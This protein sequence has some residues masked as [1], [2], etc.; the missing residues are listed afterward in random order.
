MPSALP[1]TSD[2]SNVA[3]TASKVAQFAVVSLGLNAVNDAESAKSVVTLL[4]SVLVIPSVV[5]A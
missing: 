1:V 5:F 4:E 2:K 3:S